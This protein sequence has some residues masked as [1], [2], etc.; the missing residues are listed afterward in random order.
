MT[1]RFDP[2]L[3]L[4]V[5]LILVTLTR[6][7][8]EAFALHPW[9]IADDARQ[10]L[11]WGAR[12]AD[13]AAMPGDPLADYWQQ[14]AP[15][16]YRALL[17]AA[18][19]LG[20][21]PVLLSKLLAF[22]LIILSGGLA[23]RLSGCFTQKP[24][25]Q[26]L[27]T[28]CVLA[29]IIHNDSIFSGT[30]RAFASPLILMAM[31]GLATRRYGLTVA[32]LLLSSIVY[33][34]PAIT[35]LGIFALQMLRWRF[36]FRFVLSW[37]AVIL[38][39]GTAALVLG[40]GLY[41]KSGLAGWG[42]ILRLE[43]VRHIPSLATF[44]GRSSIVGSDGGIAWICS[45]RIGFLPTIVNC[46]GN[47]DPRLFLNAA[48]TVL[49]M[50]GLWLAGRAR[51]ANA[52]EAG[53][54]PDYDLFL[55]TLASSLLCYVFTAQLAFTFHLPAR[56]SQ[57][58]LLVMGSLALGLWIG[59]LGEK[60]GKRFA[61]YRAGATCLA[62][63]IG[64]AVFATPKMRQVHPAQE[65]LFALIASTP[66]HIRIAGIARDLDMVPAELG[67][68][69]LASPEHD[70][71]YHRRYHHE[72]QTRLRASLAM[73][74]LT[75]RPIMLAY[76]RRYDVDLLIFDRGF[77]ETGILPQNYQA[78]LPPPHRISPSYDGVTTL[79]AASCRVVESRQW[80]AIFTSCL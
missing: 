16:L 80:V 8:V 73:G 26:L 60:A 35:C 28:L 34:A 72:N 41:F 6:Y 21:A 61:G 50:I 58:I 42:P 75:D 78:A 17:Y 24:P 15:P 45:P 5:G 46:H 30:P 11:T 67:R 39:G 37:K 74:Q 64:V 1:R 38:V 69:I 12:V 19:G 65:D 20:I 43:D 63:L 10:F 31:L 48:L 29:A 56:Y 2:Y 9:T 76:V 44:G 49:P 62:V 51:R 22:P 13:P 77:L 66:R 4:L 71:P 27:A 36:P 33:P 53:A 47:E 32:A 79:R 40:A 59:R 7:G 18:G 23:W 55:H 52:D 54:G 68:T 70:I 25:E 57:P 14:T 3:A